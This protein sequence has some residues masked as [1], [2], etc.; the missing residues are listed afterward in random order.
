MGRL[1]GKTCLVTAAGQGIGRASVLAMA[2]EGARVVAT[3]VNAAALESLA[4]EGIETRIL[5]VRNPASIAEA[6]A[7]C[8]APD[9]LFNCAGFVAGRFRGGGNDS[10]LR[11]RSMGLQP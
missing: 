4:A 10:G 1:N 6:V 11:R 7:A 3:D 5:N 2:R 9:A 8:P